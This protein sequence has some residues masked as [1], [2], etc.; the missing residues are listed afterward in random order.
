MYC[1]KCI[2][3]CICWEFIQFDIDLLISL[4]NVLLNKRIIRKNDPTKNGQ[5]EED[6]FIAPIRGIYEGSVP[7]GKTTKNYGTGK[8]R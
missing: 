7:G 6:D 2:R 8:R 1:Q 4:I 5:E 3:I